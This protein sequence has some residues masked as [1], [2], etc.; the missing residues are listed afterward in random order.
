MP[1]YVA[2]PDTEPMGE[3]NT[4]P[5]IDVMLVLLVMFLIALPALTHKVP[6]NIPPPG[7]ANGVPPPAHNLGISQ[8]GSLSWDGETLPANAL[9]SRLD[10]MVIDPA[11]PRLEIAAHA[12]A[13]Y[14]RVDEIMA[15]INRAGVTQVGFIGISEH[16]QA[17]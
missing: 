12:E 16:A 6:L 5:L 7:R 2:P 14:G 1:R 9:R 13:P 11:Y 8:T 17:Y 3:M 15:E 4:T 10:A